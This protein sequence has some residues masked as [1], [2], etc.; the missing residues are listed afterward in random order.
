MPVY[1]LNFMAA[2]KNVLGSFQRRWCSENVH[3]GDLFSLLKLHIEGYFFY[4]YLNYIMLPLMSYWLYMLQ[5]TTAGL[6]TQTEEN[7]QQDYLSLGFLK[8]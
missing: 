7:W 8:I 2:A 4:C 5:C 3:G 6:F 1:Q